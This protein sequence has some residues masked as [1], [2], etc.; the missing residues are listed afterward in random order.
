MQ[1]N[2]KQNIK[3]KNNQTNKH[4]TIL[5]SDSH[6]ESLRLTTKRRTTFFFVTESRNAFI[7]K[8]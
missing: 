1:C 2:T 7:I 6:S 3:N 8:K 4:N 5:F